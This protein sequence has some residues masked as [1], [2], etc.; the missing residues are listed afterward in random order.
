MAHTF[1][2]SW[3]Y[4]W[5]NMSSLATFSLTYPF[6]VILYDQNK[7][8]LGMGLLEELPRATVLLIFPI[9]TKV[10]GNEEERTWKWWGLVQFCQFSCLT[11][12][13]LKKHREYVYYAHREYMAIS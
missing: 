9:Q 10:K 8:I 4:Q 13:C 5:K 2:S 11:S 1:Q 3:R 7:R 6:I 12:L